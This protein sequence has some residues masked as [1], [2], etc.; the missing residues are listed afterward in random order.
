M[1][2]AA[3]NSDVRETQVG[4]RT[5]QVEFVCPEQGS[6]NTTTIASTFM[7]LGVRYLAKQEANKITLILPNAMLSQS[8]DRFEMRART[9]RESATVTRHT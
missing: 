2:P 6:V 3:K 8:F 4:V 5:P 9:W 1:T 7:I